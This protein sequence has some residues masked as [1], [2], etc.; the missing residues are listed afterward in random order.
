M[1][2]SSSPA[3]ADTGCSWVRT[4][5]QGCR[6]PESEAGAFLAGEGC[7]VSAANTTAAEA[8]TA[9]RAL[10]GWA[11]RTA[12]PDD[13]ASLHEI[14][15]GWRRCRWPSATPAGC[16]TPPTRPLRRPASLWGCPC[17]RSPTR[18]D[19]EEQDPL[20]RPALPGAGRRPWVR[21]PPRCPWPERG[22]FTVLRHSGVSGSSARRICRTSWRHWLASALS[23]QPVVSS[24]PSWRTRSSASFADARREAGSLGSGSG[25]VI[26][27]DHD[28]AVWEGAGDEG[29]GGE[30]AVERAGSPRSHAWLLI[31]LSWTKAWFQEPLTSV[32]GRGGPACGAV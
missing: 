24:D 10:R 6:C 2:W 25:A 26:G 28:G 23:T 11:A 22:D 14:S 29:V 1:S 5:R 18:S 3:A 15:T 13:K 30:V 19:P 32:T 4:G 7:S 8:E 21:I 20:A 17:S 16:R 12:V 9:L 27:V 31:R